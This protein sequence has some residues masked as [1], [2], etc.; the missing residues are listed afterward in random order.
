MIIR[1][2]HLAFGH[3]GEGDMDQL[4]STSAQGDF[5][6][7]SSLFQP[8]IEGLNNRITAQGT[9]RRLIQNSPG[10]SMTA[11]SQRSMS[12][13]GGTRLVGMGSQAQVGS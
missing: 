2:K 7:F 10:A 9:D 11:V 4:T 13:A 12:M 6:M 3:Q 8:G 5:G 1:V